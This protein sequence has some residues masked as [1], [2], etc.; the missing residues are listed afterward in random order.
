[1]KPR[2]ADGALLPSTMNSFVMVRLPKSSRSSYTP[3]ASDG[4][5]GTISIVNRSIEQF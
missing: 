3:L 4:L 2:G 1:M 5:P